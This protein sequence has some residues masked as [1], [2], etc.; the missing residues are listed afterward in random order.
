MRPLSDKYHDACC[1]I[2]EPRGKDCPIGASLLSLG[3]EPVLNPGRHV[4]SGATSTYLA[5]PSC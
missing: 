5:A 3:T 1:C 2:G 4:S